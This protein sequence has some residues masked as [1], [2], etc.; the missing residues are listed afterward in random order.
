MVPKHT[1]IS[2]KEKKELLEEYRISLKD[3]PRITMSD[4]AIA[5]MDLTTDDVIRVDRPSPTSKNTVFY[6]RVVK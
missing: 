6:R 1:K 2:D 5:G 3:L 4:P